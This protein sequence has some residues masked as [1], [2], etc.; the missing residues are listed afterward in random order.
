MKI[1]TVDNGKI[2]LI[3]DLQQPLILRTKSGDF[4]T[5]QMKTDRILIEHDEQVAEFK[6]GLITTYPLISGGE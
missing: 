1:E 2:L 6:K 3:E 5:V 4:I